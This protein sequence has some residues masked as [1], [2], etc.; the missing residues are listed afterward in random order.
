MQECLLSEMMYT[1]IT[2]FVEY[3]EQNGGNSQV[4]HRGQKASVV[5]EIEDEEIRQQAECAF[6]QALADE[7]VIVPDSYGIK[8]AEWAVV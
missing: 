5:Q 2:V 4:L 3:Y 6:R 7:A 8:Q 1:F